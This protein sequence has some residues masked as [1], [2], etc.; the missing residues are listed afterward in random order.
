[1]RIAAFSVGLL[2]LLSSGATGQEATFTPGR[3]YELTVETPLREVTLH[4]ENIGIPDRQPDLPARFTVIRGMSADTVIIRFWTWQDH[5]LRTLFN[6]ADRGGSK[7]FAVATA[8]LQHRTVPIYPKNPSFT[9]GAVLIPVKM[10]FGAF[11]FSKDVTLG[12]S[13][14]VRWRTNYRNEWFAHALVS[15]G[16]TSVSVDSAS[17]KGSVTQPL[18]LSAVTPSLGLVFD[19]DGFQFGVFSGIDL[20]SRNARFNW[21]YQSKPWLSVGLGYSMLTRSSRSAATT[22]ETQ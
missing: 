2:L 22:E 21:Q 13:A 3:A 7:Y 6:R 9:A 1:M 19:F 4:G 20:I 8:D 11:D 14:G 16:I 17:T 10:R 5:E 15:F 12:P 18:D